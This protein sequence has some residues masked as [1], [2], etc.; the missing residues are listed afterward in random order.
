MR[1]ET[2][3]GEKETPRE[4][5]DEQEGGKS[6]FAR[7]FPAVTIYVYIITGITHI[8]EIIPPKG[9]CCTSH[10]VHAIRSKIHD[11]AQQNYG[12][13]RISYEINTRNP[14]D[15]GTLIATAKMA[16][17]NVG[18]KLLPCLLKSTE[19]SRSTFRSIYRDKATDI[20]I[21]IK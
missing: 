10:P 21:I 20:K 14:R 5:E 18:K 2:R 15:D 8:H 12:I 6:N 19:S 9:G 1:K 16:W 3:S 11:V 13:F 4:K 7:I 17:V